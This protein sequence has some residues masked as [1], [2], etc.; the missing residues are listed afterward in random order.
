MI[1]CRPLLRGVPRVGS[2]TSL[3]LLRHSDFPTFPPRSLAF[4]RQFATWRNVGIS[5]VPEQPL[6]ARA[7]LLDPGGVVA[8][9]L[10]GRASQTGAPMLPSADQMASASTTMG[11]RDS[12]TRPVHSLSTLRGQHCYWLAQDS[13]PVGGQPYRSGLPPAGCNERFPLLHRFLLSQAWPGAPDLPAFPSSRS[14]R[15]LG[16]PVPDA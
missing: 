2:P 14:L 3:L 4:A 11:F 1:R 16:N 13:L 10:S 9:D 6:C 7:P 15:N 12:F 8:P 5:Q